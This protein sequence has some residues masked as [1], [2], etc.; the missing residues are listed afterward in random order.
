MLGDQDASISLT[1]VSQPSSLV[2]AGEGLRLIQALVAA[3]PQRSVLVLS[4]RPAPTGLPATVRWATTS[5]GLSAWP[6]DPFLFAWRGTRPVLLQRP[7]LQAGREADAAMAG[8]VQRHWAPEWKAR[9][10]EPSLET[11]TVA[12]HAGQ[13]LLDGRDLWLSLHSLEPEILSRLGRETVPVGEFST[14]AGI[15]AYLRAAEGAAESL[16]RTLGADVRWIHPLPRGPG[17]PSAMA[18]LGA[19]AGLDLDSYLTLLPGKRALVASLAAGIAAVGRAPAA[20]LDSVASF[21][22]L[23]VRG[24][25]LRSRLLGA[26]AEPSNSVLEA[27]LEVV[28]RHLASAG[29]E[30]ARTPLVRIPTTL[31]RDRAGVDYAEFHLTWNNLVLEPVDS[32]FRAEGFEMAFP[33][34][35]RA[36]EALLAER[37][38]AWA[39]LPPLRRS[40]VLGGGYRCASNHFRR[41]QASP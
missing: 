29:L 15:A 11:S 12:F 36:V 5:K 38:V 4:D 40:I 35:D 1:V 14:A 2:E 9:W 7:N 20:D 6:R 10:Q 22:E 39:R 23:G 19:G 16:G 27:Y 26:A 25:A 41:P 34:V 3:R 32:G 18:N 17:A 30:V 37:G 31:F 21:F 24:E 13:L 8:E 33:S 28:A